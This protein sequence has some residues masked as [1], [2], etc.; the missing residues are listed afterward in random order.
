MN[1]FKLFSIVSI[2]FCLP[3]LASPA[4]SCVG[5]ILTVAIFQSADQNVMGNMLSVFINERT[6]TTVLL[7]KVST[8]ADCFRLVK[9]GDAD[10]FIGYIG[11]SLPD[12][13]QVLAGGSPEE[14]YS[15]VKQYYRENFGMVWLKP[16][17]Y[18]GPIPVGSDG[19]GSKGSLACVVTTRKVLDRFPI[20]D[21]VINKL[22]NRIDDNAMKELIA[23]I[24]SSGNAEQVV[25]AFLKKRNLI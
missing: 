13:K 2:L 1:R 7:K 10:I 6:G 8:M 11:A 23:S 9:D 4:K 19:A 21:R 22:S 17:E 14:T 15:L 12:K 3:L 20:L 16:Y 24:A 18:H 25:K 5:R